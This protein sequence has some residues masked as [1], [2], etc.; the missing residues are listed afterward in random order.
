MASREREVIAPLYLALVGPHLV[1]CIQ[2]W[3]T[4]HKKDTEL[5]E[6]VHKRITKVIK[7]AG[8]PLLRGKVAETGLV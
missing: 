8:T 3:G 6:Q 4:Q 5:L 7:R 2:A 1:Y